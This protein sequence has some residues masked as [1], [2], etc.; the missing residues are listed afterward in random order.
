MLKRF[1]LLTFMLIFALCAVGQ[2]L[3]E[4]AEPAATDP[5]A[6][7]PAT[8]S[9]YLDG[10]RETLRQAQQRLIALGILKGGADGAYG[11]KTEAALRKYQAENGLVESGHLDAATFALLTYIDPT[12]ATA[13]DVQ[14][15]LIDLGYLRGSADG[16]I[17]P[18]SVEALKLFQRI[19]GLSATGKVND[20]T[21]ELLFSDLAVA[22]PA[23]LSGGSKG[24]EV[25]KLQR[26]L[27]QLGFLAGEAD[28]SY[29]QSTTVAV[30]AFQK[31]LMDQGYTDGITA[32]GVA[33]ALTQFAL[34]SD[35]YSSYLR[36]VR[37][38]E[39]DDEALRVERRLVGL[40]YL[41]LQADNMIDDDTLEAVKLFQ[42]QMEMQPDALLDRETL[43]ALFSADAAV[44]DHCAPHDIASG[45]S[46][47]V[48]R[49]LETALI[50]GGMMSKMPNGK[51]NATVEDAVDR[52]YKYLLSRQD[53]K[54]ELFADRKSLSRDAMIALENGLLGYRSDDMDDEAEATRVQRRLYSLCYL[55]KT[56]VDGK[57]GRN[58]RDALLEFQQANRIF[59]TGT[60]D[61][62]T[63]EY[64]FSSR[65]LA[66]P[67]PYRVEVSIDRQVVE[68]YSLNDAGGYD[69]EQ[70]FKCSTGLHD[71][72]PRG[73]YLDGFP[74]NR[75]HHFE[76]FNCWAQYS[77]E[78]TGDIMFHSVIY[79]TNS[80]NSLRSG[81]LYALGNPASHGCIRLS[82]DDAKWLFEHCKRG[83][84]AIII[85]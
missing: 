14:Q 24:E 62:A 79:G 39:A 52:T 68:V 51:Y 15:K 10:E 46:N 54:A 63:Q 55:D 71:S 47:A 67:Y 7:D 37:P 27:I 11:P 3:A 65:A 59:E 45:D 78:I 26:A 76:K 23:A 74:V 70:S 8:V 64:L 82:V 85:Y 50:S 73:I 61:R 12:N 13:A 57:F 34:Y 35:Q 48:V 9:G 17:G 1:F 18:K 41:D 84:L 19:N 40:G 75:W 29:G 60:A 77:F 36:D 32:D 33:S 42:R 69:L 53:E 43:E 22:V 44:A 56:G 6:V 25:E 49:D 30:K 80:E 72:T 21:L 66:K 16:I 58:T 31:H 28:G 38:G 81:S 83:T 2:A 20:D 5:A 4:E